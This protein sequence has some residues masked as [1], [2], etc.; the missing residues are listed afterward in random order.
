[1]RGRQRRASWAGQA[2]SSGR[3]AAASAERAP[4]QDISCPSPRS[5]RVAH[6]VQEGERREETHPAAELLPVVDEEL[7]ALL[8]DGLVAA[9]LEDLSEQALGPEHVLVAADGRALRELAELSRPSGDG[10]L[11]KRG[12]RRR[13]GRRRARGSGGGGR[14]VGALGEDRAERELAG[15]QQRRPRAAVGER[16]RRCASA[17]CA[18]RSRR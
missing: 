11:F 1:M 15:L 10:A 18:D 7:G 13:L 6:P 5:P 14:R 8:P 3:R 2:E 16:R 4:G 12:R 9:G 17:S